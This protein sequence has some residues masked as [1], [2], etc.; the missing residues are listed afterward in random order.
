MRLRAHRR[1]S[2]LGLHAYELKAPRPRV[3]RTKI[4]ALGEAYFVLANGMAA[5]E[6]TPALPEANHLGLVSALLRHRL[7]GTKRFI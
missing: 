7:S 5:F 1:L 4:S 3:P 6:R 2:V